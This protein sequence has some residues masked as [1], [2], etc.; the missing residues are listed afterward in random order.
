MGLSLF[1]LK[2]RWDGHLPLSPF[3]LKGNGNSDGMATDSFS[4]KGN[5]DGMEKSLYVM[6]WPL[7][8]IL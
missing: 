7:I 3:Y 6:E 1:Y 2:G 5:S 8:P 4:L